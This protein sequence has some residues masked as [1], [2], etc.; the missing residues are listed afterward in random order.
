MTRGQNPVGFSHMYVLKK[1]P[2]SG[3]VH[4]SHRSWRQLFLCFLPCFN[5]FQHNLTWSIPFICICQAGFVILMCVLL[6]C[7]NFIEEFYNWCV[8]HNYIAI[9]KIWIRHKLRYFPKFQDI[10]K[11]QINSQFAAE[12]R[13]KWPQKEAESFP[14][15]SISEGGD[16]FSVGADT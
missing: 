12:N 7:C 3:G 11:S 5:L 4:D 6:T 9:W 10:K 14:L 2:C 1:G 15:P 13:P 16:V 8:Y